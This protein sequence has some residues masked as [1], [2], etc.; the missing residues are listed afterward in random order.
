LF[1]LIEPTFE[2]ISIFDNNF[3]VEFSWGLPKREKKKLS[4]HVLMWLS[5]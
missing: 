3:S 1:T 2:S 4:C 5:N